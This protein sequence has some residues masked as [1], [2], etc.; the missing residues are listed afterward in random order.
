MSMLQQIQDEFE[1][2]KMDIRKIIEDTIVTSKNIRSSTLAEI[3]PIL[4]LI[5]SFEFR[6]PG[7]FTGGTYSGIRVTEDGIETYKSGARTG[8]IQS[9]GDLSFGSDLSAAATT[10]FLIFSQDQTYNGEALGAGDVMIGD[11]SA[12]K[13]NILWDKSTG[14]MYFRIGTSINGT[15]SSSFVSYGKQC[16]YTG[17]TQSTTT[18]VYADVASW[19]ENYAEGFSVSGAIITVEETGLYQIICRT[20]WDPNGTGFR[21]AGLTLNG[22][23]SNPAANTQ[24]SASVYGYT[25][26]IDELTLTAGDEIKVAVRQTSGG[27]LNLYS[28]NLVI[29]RIR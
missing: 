14:E 17:A 24:G 9:D 22:S 20:T 18:G 11:N 10:G 21:D 15:L 8:F 12:S 1:K 26:G 23:P 27:N 6:T 3:S 7:D 2:L 5:Q 19:T 4:G 29:R 13:P 16:R 28:A 25:T